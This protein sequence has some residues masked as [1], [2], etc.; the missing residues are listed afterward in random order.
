[1]LGLYY[2]S[3]KWYVTFS[4][5]QWNGQF[6]YKNYLRVFES[7]KQIRQFFKNDFQVKPHIN[8]DKTIIYTYFV[9]F[10]IQLQK[11]A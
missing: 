5:A 8:I 6:C 7:V 9:S 1:M 2:Y 11:H 10:K 3:I 4:C